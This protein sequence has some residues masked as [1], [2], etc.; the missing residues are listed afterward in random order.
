[1]EY[2][3]PAKSTGDLIDNKIVNK[4]AKVSRSSPQNNSET[5]TNKYDR[6]IPKKCLC[7]YCNAYVLVKGT[8]TVVNTAAQGQPKNDAN[9]MVIKIVHHLLNA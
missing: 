8:I 7:D 5:I 4:I 2:K 1:M 9:K 3:K 6:E